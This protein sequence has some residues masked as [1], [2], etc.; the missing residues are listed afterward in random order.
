MFKED[1]FE[2]HWNVTFSDYSVH[3]SKR[4]TQ[5]Y[6]FVHLAS[7]SNGELATVDRFTGGCVLMAET[8][9]E[10]ELT[11]VSKLAGKLSIK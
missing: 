7:T 4:D 5:N 2:K 11:G 10:V 3:A 6:Q 1:S 8:L 9:R